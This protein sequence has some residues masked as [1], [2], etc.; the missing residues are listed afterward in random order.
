[1]IHYK[2][3]QPNLIKR[4]GY[5]C[6]VHEVFTEDGYILALHRIPSGLKSDN[7]KDKSHKIPVIIQHGNFQSSADWMLNDRENALRKVELHLYTYI[8]V[9]ACINYFYFFLHIFTALILADNGYDVWLV[10]KIYIF[11]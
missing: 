9:Y 10:R 11:L 4:N 1:M 5:Q 2:T 8:S 6:E 3:F 7:N